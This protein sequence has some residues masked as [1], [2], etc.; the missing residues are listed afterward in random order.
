MKYSISIIWERVLQETRKEI[1]EFQ[2]IKNRL[3]K[4]A[5]LK[6]VHELAARLS[7]SISMTE[8]KMFLTKVYVVTEPI[9]KRLTV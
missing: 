3:I 6:G 1:K 9:K 2:Q 7:N 5:L 8:K 4:K